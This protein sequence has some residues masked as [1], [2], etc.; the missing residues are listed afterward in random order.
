MKINPASISAKP[1]G[2]AGGD[3]FTPARSWFLHCQAFDWLI[4]PPSTKGR[5]VVPGDTCDAAAVCAVRKRTE[6]TGVMWL[7]FCAEHRPSPE[8]VSRQGG[9]IYE[10][11]PAAATP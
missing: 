4:L 1:T 10:Y 7:P 9:E 5:A 11:H 8:A 2:K 6:A 3:D